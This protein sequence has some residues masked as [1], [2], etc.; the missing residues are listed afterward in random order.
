MTTTTETTLETV[1]ARVYLAGLPFAE[2][3]RAKRVLACKWDA[4]RRMW[5]VGKA[6]LAA[7]TAFVEGIGRPVMVATEGSRAVAASLDLADD[8]PAGVVADK[9]EEAGRTAEAARVR[10]G[11]T[12]VEDPK[13]IRLTGKGRYKGR[14]YY[15]GAITRDGAK[16]RLLT[17]P[18]AKGEYLDFWAACSEVTQTKTYE[19]REVWDGR[20]Y[21]GRTELRYT[22]LGS[23]AA[24]VRR[25]TRNAGT[26]RERVQC[27]ECDARH[28]AGESCPDC[29]GC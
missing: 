26:G 16:V 10:D 12:A 11:K 9:L 19:P 14:E 29:G 13:T 25:Q 18:D 3:D 6:K 24:F 21:S 15:A 22:T 7:A 4:D 28:A 20:Q 27:P 2:K 8:A 17:L 5:W 1:G 23:I